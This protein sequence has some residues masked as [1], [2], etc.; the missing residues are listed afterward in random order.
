MQVTIT[1][2]MKGGWVCSSSS[3]NAVRTTKAR[4]TY[5]SAGSCALHE[6][7]LAVHVSDVG[8]HGTDLSVERDNGASVVVQLI[9]RQKP[10]TR[11]ARLAL[12]SVSPLG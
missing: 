9:E 5:H 8:A 11:Y 10:A 6:V 4:A 1:E 2:F 3:T 7:E 12:T